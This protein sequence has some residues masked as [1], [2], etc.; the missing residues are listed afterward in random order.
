M[1]RR[2]PKKKKPSS[3]ER[4]VVYINVC[5]YTFFVYAF[6]SYELAPVNACLTTIP[7]AAFSIASYPPLAWA[8]IALG[9]IGLVLN[10]TKVIS[11]ADHQHPHVKYMKIAILIVLLILLVLLALSFNI[12]C[13]HI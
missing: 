3:T 10:A 6:L 2:T 12:R 5:I 11:M 8:I 7:K 9:T 1:P 13:L 4:L